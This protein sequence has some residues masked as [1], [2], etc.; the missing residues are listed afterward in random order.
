M[1]FRYSNFC[2]EFLFKLKNDLIRKLKLISKCMI[3]QT[4]KQIITTHI[5]LNISRSKNSQTMKFG[6]LI[7]S[8]VRKILFFFKNHAEKEAGR[9]V[10]DFSLFS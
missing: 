3:L 1:F 4:A 8:N 5:L 6:Q 7:A 9:L 10:S 2:P